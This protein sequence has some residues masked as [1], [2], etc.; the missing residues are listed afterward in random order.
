[1]RLLQLLERKGY[2][3]TIDVLVYLCPG[4]LGDLFDRARSVTLL[5]RQSLPPDSNNARDGA[6]DRKQAIPH[7]S[8]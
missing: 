2:P 7:P 4:P 3:F 5:S 6:L 8:V 1:M